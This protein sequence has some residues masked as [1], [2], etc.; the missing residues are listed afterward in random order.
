[1]S[2]PSK[3]SDLWRADDSEEDPIFGGTAELSLRLDEAAATTPNAPAVHPPLPLR[4]AVPQDQQPRVAEGEAT[5]IS[6]DTR[7]SP[8]ASPTRNEAPPPPSPQASSPPPRRR[9]RRRRGRR[10]AASGQEPSGTPASAASHG[11]GSS[12]TV[13]ATTAANG[14]RLLAPGSTNRHGIRPEIWNLI[15]AGLRPENADF[16]NSL[17]DDIISAPPHQPESESG[18]EPTPKRRRR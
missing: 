10:T 13:A 12:A 11:V 2:T 16:G 8:E 17:F 3:H 4:P 14:V 6:Q 1:M 5:S 18:P 9:R 15:A 7:P